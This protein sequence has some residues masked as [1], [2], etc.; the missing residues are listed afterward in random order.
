MKLTELRQRILAAMADEGSTMEQIAK[1]ID[2][3]N[4]C[5][6]EHMRALEKAGA[7]HRARVAYNVCYWFKDK[8][9]AIQC[10]QAHSEAKNAAPL[11]H[12]AVKVATKFDRDAQI[13]VPKGVKVQEG[14]A[15]KGL[16]FAEQA[17]PVV[18]GWATLG[19]GRY[20]EAA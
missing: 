15:F 2:R 18:G 14:P 1:A 20:L 12:I 13:V 8:A 17:G 16:G 11:V 4:D 6:R 19:V 5:A 10:L 3:T 7:V 9:K